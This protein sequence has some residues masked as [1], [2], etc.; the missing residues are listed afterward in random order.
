MQAL[1][2]AAGEGTRLRPLTLERPKPM[3]ELLGKPIL[4]HTIDNL[5]A[6]IDELVIVVR[7][8]A[9]AIKSHFGSSW[10]GRHIQYVEQEKANGTGNALFAARSILEP[11]GKFVSIMG[12][13]VSGGRAIEEAL[14]YDYALLVRTHEHPEH[15]GVV[16]LK[17]DGT[18]RNMI[19]HPKVPP[20]N[21]VSTGTMVL[22][23]GIFEATLHLNSDRQ[24]YLLPDLLLQIAQREPVHVVKQD[25]WV[26]IDKPEDI[27][28][29]EEAL[30][31]AE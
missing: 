12:D 15:F 30:R 18:I 20:S 13:N 24:E 3:V 16:E 9:E 27:P 26:S 17:E 2:L 22:S 8:K 25:F 7:Y 14:Q 10:K 5:P 21:L 23:P 6:S 4:E 29:A 31:L 19:E 28:G 11:R 1:I